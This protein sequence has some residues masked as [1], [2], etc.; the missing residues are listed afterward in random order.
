M[1]VENVLQLVTNGD[2]LHQSSGEA[3]AHA[4]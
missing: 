4:E 1:A 3:L 2:E